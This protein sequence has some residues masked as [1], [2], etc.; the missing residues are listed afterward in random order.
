MQIDTGRCCPWRQSLNYLPTLYKID[1]TQII[2][3]KLNYQK[4][5][6]STSYVTTLPE[7]FLER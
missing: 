4:F 6:I 3:F 7:S 2:S 5:A 1:K